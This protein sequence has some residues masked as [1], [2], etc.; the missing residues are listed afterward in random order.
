MK[1]ALIGTG[2]MGFAI[3]ELAPRFG[4]DILLRINE[5]NREVLHSEEFKSM[6]VA[7]EFTRPEA[8]IENLYA[9]L[10]AGVPVVCGTTGW[11][12]QIDA[13]TADFKAKKGALIYSSNFSIGVNIFF[14]LNRIVSGWMKS[15]PQYSPGLIEIHHVNKIDKPSGTAVSLA[16][17]IIADHPGFKGWKLQN[18]DDEL[19]G[20]VLPIESN[21]EHD[22][23]GIHTVHWNSKIDSITLHHE[24]NSREGF[25]SGALEA[26]H[27]IK[28]KTGVFT[29]KDILFPTKTSS[30]P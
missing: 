22:T 5:N 24:A 25:A 16:K 4:D 12:D 17:D 27:W 6:D 26:A 2:K 13:V 3:G 14:E 21:R 9:C 7:I 15:F 10:E 28:D 1:I 29:M 20:D 11:H 23:I 19:P 30:N 18:G 8:V